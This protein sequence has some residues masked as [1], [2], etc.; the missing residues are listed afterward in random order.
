MAEHKIT[1]SARR[2]LEAVARGEAVQIRRSNPY[3]TVVGTSDRAVPRPVLDAVRELVRIDF[4]S[5]STWESPYVL[6]AAGEQW[7][8]DSATNMERS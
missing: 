7:L 2:F 6:T 1:P 5:G 3:R 8:R 4:A